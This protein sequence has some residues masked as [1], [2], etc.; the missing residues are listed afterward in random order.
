[1]ELALEEA[2]FLGFVALMSTPRRHLAALP[3]PRT[4]SPILSSVLVQALKRSHCRVKIGNTMSQ[5]SLFILVSL[6][7]LGCKPAMDLAGTWRHDQRSTPLIPLAGPKDQRGETPIFF[8]LNKDK[9][10]EF[11]GMKG[12]YRQEGNDVILTTDSP[13]WL[14]EDTKSGVRVGNST[15]SRLVY[16]PSRGGLEWTLQNPQMT[17]PYTLLFKKSQSLR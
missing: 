8:V 10:F 7:F 9:T 3:H 1:M 15:V 17:K 6:F 12:T 4:D 5:R 11:A 2:F 14:L 13:M 16:N